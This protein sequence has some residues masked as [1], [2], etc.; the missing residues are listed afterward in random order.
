MQQRPPEVMV[1]QIAFEQL[2]TILVFWRVSAP[3]LD[4]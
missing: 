3:I 1:A 4:S 2:D